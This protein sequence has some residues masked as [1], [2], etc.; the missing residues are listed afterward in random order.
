MLLR[1]VRRLKEEGDFPHADRPLAFANLK[2]IT[3]VQNDA[4]GEVLQAVQVDL[5]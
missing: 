1:V 5:K 2:L 4:T 3:F